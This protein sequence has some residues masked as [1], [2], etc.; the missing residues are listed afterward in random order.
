MPTYLEV[1]P[2]EL[3]SNHIY[4]C[5]VKHLYAAFS[6]VKQCNLFLQETVMATNL[7]V[8]LFFKFSAG[9]EK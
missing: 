7:H 3:L 9:V 1:I 8:C 4:N 6:M 5:T 2:I